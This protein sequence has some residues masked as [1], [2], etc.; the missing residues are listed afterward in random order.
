[1]KLNDPIS[2][3]DVFQRAHMLI[4]LDY[5]IKSIPFWRKVI[6]RRAIAGAGKHS[7]GGFQQWFKL[8]VEK[9]FI[10]IKKKT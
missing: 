2:I 4:D 5:Y 8:D 3:D 7:V 6:T 10:E 1:M 9:D